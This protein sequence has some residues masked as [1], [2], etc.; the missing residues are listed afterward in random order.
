MVSR[1]TGKPLGPVDSPIEEGDYLVSSKNGEIRLSDEPW[2]QCLPTRSIS[3][4][5][6]FRD[7]VRARDGRCVFT[8]IV[9]IFADVDDWLTFESVHVFPPEREPLWIDQDLGR[10]ISDMDDATGAS[11]INSTQNGLLMQ[12]NM[13]AFWDQYLIS[14]NPDVSTPVPAEKGELG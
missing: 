14:V 12:S 3:G 4:E 10:W 1:T 2:V 9:N 6:R 8:G 5:D 11:K 13:Q 7:G